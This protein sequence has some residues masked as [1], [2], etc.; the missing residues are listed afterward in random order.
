MKHKFIFLVFL[1]IIL[2]PVTAQTYSSVITDREIYDFMNWMVKNDKKT[3][4]E[5]FGKSRKASNK[6]A[7]WDKSNF[8]TN[9]KSNDIQY[10]EQDNKYL[11]K[12]SNEG[13]D[14][15]FTQADKSFLLEQYAAINS[16]VWKKGFSGKKIEK[17]DVV[18]DSDLDQYSI[19]MFTLDKEFVIIY[20]VFYCGYGCAFGKYYLYKFIGDKKW[21]FVTAVNQWTT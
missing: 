2:M 13:L 7:L 15:L 11:F 5:I 8:V 9:N 18:E 10:F 1:T 4:K 12:R 20:K 3:E 19:P 16:S 6:M 17:K 21:K 14:T